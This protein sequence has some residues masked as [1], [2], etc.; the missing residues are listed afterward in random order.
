M[1]RKQK[2]SRTQEGQDKDERKLNH[3]KEEDRGI[4]KGMRNRVLSAEK[5]SKFLFDL[6]KNWKVTWLAV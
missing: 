3:D 2:W 4:K 6:L 1:E 5:H